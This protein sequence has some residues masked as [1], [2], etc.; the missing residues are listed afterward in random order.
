MEKHEKSSPDY[1]CWSKLDTWSLKEAALLLHALDPL[2]YRQVKFNLREVPNNPE[3]GEAYK[4]FLILNNVTR[5]HRYSENTGISIEMIYTIVEQ[6]ALPM[7]EALRTELE[8][9]FR[10]N[11]KYS[12]LL[13]LSIL[14]IKIFQPANAGTS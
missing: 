4:I 10:V 9:R 7:P 6:K 3:L 14:P 1:T 8:T 5:N 11:S 13:S 2:A 12:K